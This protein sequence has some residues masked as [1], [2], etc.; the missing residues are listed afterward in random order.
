M[1]IEELLEKEKKEFELLKSK[2]EFVGDPIDPTK[3]VKKN[4]T[5]ALGYSGSIYTDGGIFILD[6]SYSDGA[7]PP[8][9][10]DSSLT[11]DNDGCFGYSSTHYDG[12]T[13]LDNT[14]T[15]AFA[16]VGFVLG[17]GGG[18]GGGSS[19]DLTQGLTSEAEYTPWK[20]SS[21]LEN[22]VYYRIITANSVN[23]TAGL[24]TIELFTTTTPVQYILHTGGSYALDNDGYNYTLNTMNGYI[25]Y[26]TSSSKFF[27][28]VYT[29]QADTMNYRVFVIYQRPQPV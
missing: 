1:N 20:F 6:Q 19:F 15:N 22:K 2:H 8:T 4:W 5:S 26:K 25:Y 11:F 10:Y 24:N 28:Q 13:N 29:E 27:L 23:V 21:V 7:T 3:F 12:S 9:G 16:T 17:S 14:K 18:G